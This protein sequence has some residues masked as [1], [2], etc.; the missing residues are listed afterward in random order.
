MAQVVANHMAVEQVRD[1][2]FEEAGRVLDE[3]VQVHCVLVRSSCINDRH[4]SLPIQ[5]LHAGFKIHYSARL[6]RPPQLWLG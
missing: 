5:V 4:P 3:D 2:G 1:G 6:Y